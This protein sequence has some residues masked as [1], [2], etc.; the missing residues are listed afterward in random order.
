MSRPVT[1]EKDAVVDGVVF[2]MDGAFSSPSVTVRV[3]AVVIFRNCIF[4]RPGDDAQSHVLV[5]ETGKATFVGCVFRGST[6]TASPVV[7][8][9]VAGPGLGSDVQIAY[10]YNNT[11]NTLFAAGTAVGTGNH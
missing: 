9:S 5:E 2:S 10:S 6:V 7:S 1:C 11:G 3:G 8:H 4:E